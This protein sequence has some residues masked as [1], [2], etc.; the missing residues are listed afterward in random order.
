MRRHLVYLLTLSLPDP[1]D[2]VP[3]NHNTFIAFPKI[4]ENLRQLRRIVLRARQ[5]TA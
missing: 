3:S 2:D 4:R 1:L 5:L